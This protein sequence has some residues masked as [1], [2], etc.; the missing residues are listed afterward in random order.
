[1]LAGLVFPTAGSAEV[2]GAAPSAAVAR[3]QIGYLSDRPSLYDH[4]TPEA[5]LELAGRLSDT[6]PAARRRRSG[7]LM[8]RLGLAS[9]RGVPLRRLSAG[10]RQRV[11]LALALLAAPPILL[12]DEP[13]GD[14]DPMV[15]AAARALLAELRAAGTTIVLSTHALGDVEATCDR[16]GIMVAGRIRRAGA[17][18]A[19]CGGL[20]GT[21][22]VLKEAGTNTAPVELSADADVDAFVRAALNRGASLVSVTPRLDS[23]AD[24]L[25]REVAQWA[26]A[27]EDSR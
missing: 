26:P 17:P 4:L 27:P 19:L 10:M 24:V 11:A 13:M 18:A 14:L 23:L 16:V 1:M 7:E 2:C 21:T 8:D 20:R 5:T 12:L 22:V 25:A 6:P 15:H 3:G 9:A